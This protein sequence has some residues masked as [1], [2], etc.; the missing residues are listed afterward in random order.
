MKKIIC[1][2]ATLLVFSCAFP[3]TKEGMMTTSY[4]SPKK[5]GSKIFVKESTG[6]SV[7]LPFWTSEI[8]NDNFTAAVKESLLRSKAFSDISSNWEDDWGL[9]IEIREVN[10]P[11]AGADFTVTTDVKYTLYSKGKK[12][13]ETTIRESATVRI[14]ESFI[15]VQRLRLANERSAKANI[16]KFIEKLSEQK[17]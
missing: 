14:D 17:L 7:T 12:S 6:G 16:K 3:S 11:F 10:Q 5:I 2:S 4:T 15:G 1:L 13:Y 8:P 9:E